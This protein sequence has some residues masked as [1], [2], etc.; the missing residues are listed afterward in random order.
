[1][2]TNFLKNSSIKNKIMIPMIILGLFPMIALGSTLMVNDVKA[3][4]IAINEIESEVFN[5]LSIAGVKQTEIISNTMQERKFNVYEM[6]TRG[7][8]LTRIAIIDEVI[9][10]NIIQAT[11]D[12]HSL[13]ENMI[14]MGDYYVRMMIINSDGKVIIWS[15]SEEAKNFEGEDGFPTELYSDKDYFLETIVANPDDGIIFHDLTTDEFAD[16]AS[17]D[18]SYPILSYP[19]YYQGVLLG[20]F[21]VSLDMHYIYDTVY[22]ASKDENDNYIEVLDDLY[23]TS[24]LGK[25]GEIYL[26]S[27]NSKH[28]LSPSRLGNV[29]IFEQKVETEGVYNAISSGFYQGI[30][31]D[32]RGVKTLGV[33][34]LLNKDVTGTEVR[35]T[36]FLENKIVADLP[37]V[38]VVEID[39]SEAFEGQISLN[40][41][42]LNNRNIVIILV[43]LSV[44]II[45]IL[46]NRIS[47]LI[48]NSLNKLKLSMARGASGDLSKDNMDLYNVIKL[49]EQKDEIGSLASSY[50]ELL[51]NIRTMVVSTQSSIGILSH[52]SEDFLSGAE[53]INASAEEVASTSQ[54]MSD[55][56]TSQTELISSI[57][58]NVNELQHIV[59][60]IIKKIQLNTQEVAQIALQ[61]NILALNAGIEAS[62]AGDYGRGFA[63]V[64]ENV[65][66]LSDQSKLASERIETVADEIRGTLQVSFSNISSTM[67]NVVS[68][69]EE[70]AASAEEVAAAAEEMTATIEELSSS[71]GVLTDQAEQSKV[72]INK[73]KTNQKNE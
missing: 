36:D 1:M 34:I 33:S 68:V 53:E 10:G 40:Q 30:Y 70:T 54:A 41:L 25:T 18:T 51:N 61:T 69:S 46:S 45:T 39:Y 13:F 48:K 2:F 31:N 72:L 28:L 7:S 17:L 64:A 21:H 16:N 56:A 12:L 71:A 52:T 67:I 47:N 57:N 42:H 43:I 60:D 35:T 63:V 19:L 11:S 37:W 65:R 8:L 6:A 24:G 3:N 15:L 14:T 44:S 20:T 50:L 32:Y 66:K 9:S 26:V 73:F 59:D 58:E 38:I 22:F 23:E 62:R 29:N 5:K 27:S 49:S 55:G 4:D